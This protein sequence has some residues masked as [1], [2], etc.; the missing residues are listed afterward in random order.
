MCIKDVLASRD[1]L[2]DSSEFR[3]S[4][5]LSIESEIDKE[6]NTAVMCK[7]YEIIASNMTHDL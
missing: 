3:G 6:R 1:R 2:T 5:F 4:S 7:I